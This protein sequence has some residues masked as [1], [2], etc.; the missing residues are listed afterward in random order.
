[1]LGQTSN[2]MAVGL[3]GPEVVSNSPRPF[4]FLAEFRVV[5]R[6]LEPLT[7]MRSCKECMHRSCD[8]RASLTRPSVASLQRSFPPSPWPSPGCTERA[9]FLPRAATIEQTPRCCLVFE[10]LQ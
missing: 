5:K 1:M 3:G 4:E 6:D 2:Q 8:F 7:A 10:P 9:N